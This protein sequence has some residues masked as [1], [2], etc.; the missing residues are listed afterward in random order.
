MYAAHAPPP[1]CLSARTRPE[2]LASQPMCP[3]PC[4]NRGRFDTMP[5]WPS[6][7][8]SDLRVV[9]ASGL[10]QAAVDRRTH[11]P[12]TAQHS[13]GPLLSTAAYANG[14]AGLGHPSDPT[15]KATPSAKCSS[16][17]LPGRYCRA[18]LS[19]SSAHGTARQGERGERTGAN[20]SA[21]R[22][23]HDFWPGGP[24]TA[25]IVCQPCGGPGGG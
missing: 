8:R 13:T 14:A 11:G 19:Q 18:R 3:E 23:A 5:A 25:G 12:A 6:P 21:R 17:L 1:G 10:S 16:S 2:T 9:D 22:P 24:V 7:H 4:A 20:G 15:R